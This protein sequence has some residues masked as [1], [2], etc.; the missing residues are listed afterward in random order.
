MMNGERTRLIITP[1]MNEAQLAT[2]FRTERRQFVKDWTAAAD[3]VLCEAG[4]A[5]TAFTRV[6]WRPVARSAFER[7]RQGEWS[8]MLVGWSLRRHSLLRR[9]RPPGACA[10]RPP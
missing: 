9:R 3:V 2:T 5:T 1:M 10:S 6:S 4:R 7:R 8:P